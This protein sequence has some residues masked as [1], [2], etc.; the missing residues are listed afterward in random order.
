MSNEMFVTDPKRPE[1]ENYLGD[2]TTLFYTTDPRENKLLR[3]RLELVSKGEG[4]YACCLAVF[5]LDTKGTD[6]QGKPI[7]KKYQGQFF[8]SPQMGV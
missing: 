7:Y 2:Y 4:E 5:V 6:M 1:L 8:I 3:G